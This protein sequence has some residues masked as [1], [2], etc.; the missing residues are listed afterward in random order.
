MESPM[1]VATPLRKGSKSERSM[2]KPTLEDLPSPSPSPDPSPCAS[3]R[4]PGAPATPEKD[5]VP[6][7]AVDDDEHSKLV[8][9]R[10][11]IYEGLKDIER[12]PEL[13]YVPSGS[14][15]ESTA[16]D[17]LHPLIDAHDAII[18]AG[19]FFGD[20]GKGKTVDAIARHD[21]V[22]VVAR[23]NSGENAGHT[24]IGP[25]GTKYAF[26]LCPSGLLTPGKVNCIGPECM[27]DPVSFMQREISQLQ[28]DSLDYVD[29]LI[30]GDVHLVCPHHKLMDLMGSWKAPNRST[31]MGMGPVHSSK[32][33]RKG[34]RLDHLFNDRTVARRRLED[35]M[36]MYWGWLRH[37]E[38]TEQDL[39][40]A[41]KAN[42]KIQQHVLDFILAEDKAEYLFGLY[43]EYVVNN[44]AFPV[45]GD[46][47]H[48]LR[49]T[50]RK[51]EKVL[52][53]GPQS[54]WLS[55]AA[56]K[57]WDSGTS[58]N[59]CAS[60][61]LAA[62]R[63]NVVGLRTL[64][65]NIH[66]T[67]GSSRVGAGANA[68]SFVPQNYFSDTGGTK[69]T[70]EAM[71]LNWRDV[72]AKFFQSVQPNGI[73]KPGIYKNDVGSWDL[74]VAMAAA[75]CIHPSHREFGVTTGKPRIVG[76]FDCVLHAEAMACQGP[77]CSIS[78][79]DRGDDYD[80]YGVCVAYVFQH[81]EGKT[82]FSN[83]RTF[84]SGTLIRAGEQ[85]PTQEILSFCQ[86]IVKK[87][88][89]WRDTPIFARSDWWQKRTVPTVLPQPVCEL[90]DIIE[91]FTG[92]KIISIGNGPKGDEIVYI[93]RGS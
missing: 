11:Q 92:S 42:P 47:S 6:V 14:F 26:H 67:P 76:F 58:A 90:L 30:I 21:G 13:D 86:P 12:I 63:L 15:V 28:R 43:D 80:E 77:Y 93:K 53:E 56:E 2:S 36:V 27:M 20:E 74:G 66:K 33:S 82:L 38:I 22:K 52:L 62:S 59:T 64:V 24:V 89:G 23:V 71:K 3:P 88:R 35:D 41:A 61:M 91:H 72:S 85:L 69:D 79:L 68:T 46:V 9:R 4:S 25:T 84:A 16:E 32:A 7:E 39:Y 31:L 45:R 19:G 81:P 37:L 18:V 29:R 78:A 1:Q 49:E 17:I 8:Q 75:T 34:L 54:Y 65:I 83:G 70:F 44:P 5:E 87:V 55:N 10:A 51:G 73:L 50:V 57:F 48:L 40:A 60:G